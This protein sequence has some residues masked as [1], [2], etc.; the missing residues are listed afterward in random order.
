[1]PWNP[2]T[3]FVLIFLGIGSEAIQF[4]AMRKS[5]EETMRKGAAR[6]DKLRE[7]VERVQNGKEVDVKKE[8]LGVGGGEKEREER[9]WEE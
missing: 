8:L 9:E 3:F 4:I 7:L 2:Y 6:V 1:R 5:H